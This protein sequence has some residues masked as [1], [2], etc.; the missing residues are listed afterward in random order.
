MRAK[1]AKLDTYKE[2]SL[3][4]YAEYLKERTNDQILETSFGFATYRFINDGKS[5]YIVDIFVMPEERKNGLASALA[6]QIVRVGKAKG[7]SELLGTVVPTAKGSTASLK[8]LLG[9]EMEVQSA[10]QDLIVFRKDI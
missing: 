3:S 4:L 6:D 8:V 5:V 9:Y 1:L 2:R 7:C 10:A